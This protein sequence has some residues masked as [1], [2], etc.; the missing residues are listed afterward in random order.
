MSVSLL[1]ML[2]RIWPLRGKN[3]ADAP[4]QQVFVE[5]PGRMESLLSVFAS[6]EPSHFPLQDIKLIGSLLLNLVG[7]YSIDKACQA[8]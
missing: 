1:A 2:R 6:I 4:R 7:S 8:Y 5:W 3:P